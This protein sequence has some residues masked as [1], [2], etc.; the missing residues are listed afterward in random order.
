MRAIAGR[1]ESRYRYS[2]NIVY[3]NFVWVTD[4]SDEIKS[5]IE[6]CSQNILDIRNNL[7]GTNV[8]D[9]YKTI[10]MPVELIKAHK[11]LDKA[12]DKA[13]GYT[14]ADDDASR[15]AFLFKKYEA[16]TSLLPATTIKKK[17]IKKADDTQANL[18]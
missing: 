2:S 6:R 14:G 8:G 18:I 17:R 1:L 7:T 10:V 9:A 3:N 4:L 13:Y 12:I 5:E 11:D 15:V 16:L